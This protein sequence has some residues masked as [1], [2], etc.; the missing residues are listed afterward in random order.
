MINLDTDFIKI[1]GHHL[2]CMQGFQNKGYSESFIENMAS[3][4]NFLSDTPDVHV[5]IVN[6]ADNI[7]SFCPNL[8]KDGVCENPKSDLSIKKRDNLSID[9]LDLKVGEVYSYLEIL[10]KMFDILDFDKVDSIC[11]D[12]GWQRVCLFYSKF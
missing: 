12:C 9:F 11:K 2:L 7:C 3:L 5:K 10:T 6:T 4:I 1:R 8:T